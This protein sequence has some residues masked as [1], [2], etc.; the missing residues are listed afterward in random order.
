M[1]R[2]TPP[3]T[4]TPPSTTHVQSLLIRLDGITAGDYLAW[5]RDPEPPALDHCLRSV[6]T[7]AQPLGDLISIELAW[8]CQPPTTPSAAAIAA[9]FPLTP[10]VIEVIDTTTCA[11][12]R[13]LSRCAP[14]LAP[15]RTRSPGERAPNAV[16]TTP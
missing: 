12:D 9:G 7:S 16:P 4:T 1:S 2:V 13:R 6:V 15:P 14:I 11:A 8:T 5:V 10:E 3:L